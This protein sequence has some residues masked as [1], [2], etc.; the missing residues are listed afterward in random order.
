MTFSFEW[1]SPCLYET[2][3]D[4]ICLEIKSNFVLFMHDFH[5]TRQV[6]LWPHSFRLGSAFFGHF[7]WLPRGGRTC[8]EDVD[9]SRSAMVPSGVAQTRAALP[10][11]VSTV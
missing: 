9:I 3:G 2:F 6:C 7:G 1:Q 5:I 11:H 10:A 8:L 4:V